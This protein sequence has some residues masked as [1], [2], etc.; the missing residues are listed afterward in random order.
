MFLNTEGARRCHPYP[1][2]RRAPILFCSDTE[3]GHI[4]QLLSHFLRFCAILAAASIRL[5]TPEAR[6]ILPAQ[7]N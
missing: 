3:T 4:R 6:S 2:I 1:T 7:W 5:H